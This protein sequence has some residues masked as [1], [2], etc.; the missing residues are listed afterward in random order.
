[1]GCQ[2]QQ[3]CFRPH[4]VYNAHTGRYVLW[5]NAIQNSNGSGYHVF[6]SDGP[7]G[8][9]IERNPPHLAVPFVNGD[10]NLFVDDDGMAYVVYTDW[11]RQGDIV[12]EQLDSTYESGTGRF[13]RLGLVQKQ[14]SQ[15]RR[16]PI[17]WRDEGTRRD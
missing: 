15:V 12:V 11:S 1:L 14:S 3:G 10:E 5:V 9:F 16:H 8:P 4:V 2:G 7:T 13:I 6:D 17:N